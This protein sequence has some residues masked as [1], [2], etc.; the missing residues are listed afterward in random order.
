[1]SYRNMDD[2]T[3]LSEFEKWGHKVKSA[4]GWGAGLM[5]AAR[6]RDACA[7]VL[8]ERGLMRFEPCIRRAPGKP[9]PVFRGGPHIPFPGNP[10]SRVLP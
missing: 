7:R 8:A 1:M 5:Q 9:A 10:P 6:C 2:A 3:L 4:T